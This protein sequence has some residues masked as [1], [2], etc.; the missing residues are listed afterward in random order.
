MKKLVFVIFCSILL[1]IV[2][3]LGAVYISKAREGARGALQVT[4]APDSKVY[5]NDRY[6]GQTPLCKCESAD[7]LPTGNYTIRLVPINKGL[8][9]FQEKV[10]I[11]DSVLTV[12]DRKFGKNSTSEGSII[13]LTPLDDKKKIELLVVSFP[14]G[15]TALL[16]GSS[17][18]STPVLMKDPT[19]S[20]HVLK[21]KKDGYKEK[22]VRIRT[23]M[24]YKL[25]V[26]SYLSVDAEAANSYFKPT[27]APSETLTPTPEP[28][29]A[30][31][32]NKNEPTPT[33][34]VSSVLILN[35]PTGFLRVREDASVNSQ[36]IGRAIPGDSYPFVDE[37]SGW[38]QIK[39]AN[40]QL[41]WISSEYAKKQ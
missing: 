31:K 36:E 28:T 24:G 35:T 16:D 14:Q 17:I 4:S 8:S 2:F 11:S 18:G 26:A 19:E 9:E 20:D 32:N 29:E 6:L 38:Y 22:T 34:E 13:S 37:Q 3:I 10:T 25:T 21:V 15:A 41:G 30:K 39:L 12:V 7:M 33:K 40:G 23:P 1:A 27:L 5:R